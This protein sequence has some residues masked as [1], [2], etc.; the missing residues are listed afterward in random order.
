MHDK[1]RLIVDNLRLGNREWFLANCIVAKDKGDYWMLNYHKIADKNEYNVLTRGLV[2]GKDG[3]LASIP[4]FRFFNYG[5]PLAAKVDFSNADVMEKLDG[6]MVGVFFPEKDVTK[7]VWHFRSL[8]SAS[9]Q[10]RDFVIKGFVHNEEAPLLNEV[11]PYLNQITFTED[12]KDYTLIFEFVSRCNAVVTRYE[13]EQYGLYL[14]GARHLP[15]LHELS[16]DELDALGARL[17][18]RRPR[19]WDA[20]SYEE[21]LAAMAKFPKDKVYEGFII[22]DRKTGQR[23]KIKNE[24][25]LKRHRLLDKLSYKNLVPLWFGGEQDEILSYFPKTKEIFDKIEEAVRVFV[26]K[27]VD[28]LYYWQHRDGTRKDKA[29]GIQATIGKHPVVSIVFK[30]LE[31]RDEKDVIHKKVMDYLGDMAENRV[32]VLVEHLGLKDDVIEGVVDEMVG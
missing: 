32:R 25:Y 9:K 11:E 17:K 13:P 16:E 27:A 21:V 24:D 15:T 8:I 26:D 31:D 30:F 14:I 18:I 4:F 7:P 3:T 1:L 28:A 10:D 19:R 6:S 2:V 23:I 5:E 20:D 29:L 22:R 12:L